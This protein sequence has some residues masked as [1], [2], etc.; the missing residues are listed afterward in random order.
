MDTIHVGDLVRHGD[1]IW[2]VSALTTD[3][4]GER[5]RATIARD[6]WRGPHRV[7][8]QHQVGVAGL[9]FV[10]RPAFPPGLELNYRDMTITIVADN[11]GDRIRIATP[12]RSKNGIRLWPEPGIVDAERAELVLANLSTFTKEPAT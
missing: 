12:A 9:G 8:E 6:V 5:T 10:A 3:F 11:G 1:T 2:V 4:R 7:R